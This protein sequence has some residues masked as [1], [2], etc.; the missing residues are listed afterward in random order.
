MERAKK[1]ILS[2][3]STRQ[4]FPLD[5]SNTLLARL[6]RS[7]AIAGLCRLQSRDDTRYDYRQSTGVPNLRQGSRVTSHCGRDT[8]TRDCW[9]TFLRKI[10]WRS[11]N[12][13]RGLGTGA[14]Q[15]LGSV[16]QV[17]REVRYG[18]RLGKDRTGKEQDSRG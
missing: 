4:S 16:D 6:R 12:F 18:Q 15:R 11:E 13:G 1:R 9:I 5:P 3:S 17:A 2:L 14:E 10:Q 8:A 7:P